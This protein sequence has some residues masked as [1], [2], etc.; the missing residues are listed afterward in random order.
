[1]RDY[2]L[3]IRVFGFALPQKRRFT[4][5]EFLK[6]FHLNSACVDILVFL[7]VLHTL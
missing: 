3:V 7:Y 4:K 6:E 2:L 5:V 1:M